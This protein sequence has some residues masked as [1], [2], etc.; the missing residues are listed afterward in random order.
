LAPRRG[1]E[2]FQ[3]QPNSTPRSLKKQFQS[4]A[5]PA[6]ARSGPLLLAAPELGGQLIFVPGL[7]LDA[8]LWAPAGKPQFGLNWRPDGGT[9]RP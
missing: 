2:Q 6:W 5:V 9:H 7:G 4:A 1:G 8:R 3:S